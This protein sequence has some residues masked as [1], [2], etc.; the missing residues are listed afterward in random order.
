MSD[1]DLA[2][3]VSMRRYF[4]WRRRF[5]WRWKARLRRLPCRFLGHSWHTFIDGFESR[6]CGRCDRFECYWRDAWH[7]DH[8]QTWADLGYETTCTHPDHPCD[9]HRCEP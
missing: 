8:P 7:D 5:V 4:N 9:P 6:R 3:L 1:D 2:Y